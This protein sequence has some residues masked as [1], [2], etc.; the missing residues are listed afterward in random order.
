[1]QQVSLLSNQYKLVLGKNVPVWQYVLEVYPDEFWEAHLVHEIIR[2]KKKALE[3][4]LG[5]YVPSGK[6]IYTLTQLEETLVFKTT[7]RGE[8]AEIKIDVETGT[9]IQLTDTFNN[10]DNDVSQNLINVILKQA[11]RETNLKQLGRSPRFFD[12]NNP[13]NLDRIG[14]RMWSGFKASAF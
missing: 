12:V 9:Q 7:F 4:A 11:F 8:K 3:A 10:K 13:I 1:M 2:T 14:L 6:T 5:H